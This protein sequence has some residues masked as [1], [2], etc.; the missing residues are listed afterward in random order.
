MQ[1]CESFETTEKEAATA[2]AAVISAEEAYK[3]AAIDDGKTDPGEIYERKSGAK[4][5]LFIRKAEAKRAAHLKH[6]MNER[7]D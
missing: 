4:K 6:A 2:E 3:L 5:I 1:I 7:Q